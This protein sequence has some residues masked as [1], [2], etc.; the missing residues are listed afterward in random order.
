MFRIEMMIILLLQK[1]FKHR[2][3]KP[4]SAKRATVEK[5]ENIEQLLFH[6][7]FLIGTI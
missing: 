2:L 3:Q 7:I 5:S 6:I 4:A 1:K